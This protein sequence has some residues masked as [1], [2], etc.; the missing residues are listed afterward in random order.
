MSK[1]KTKEMKT[2]ELVDELGKDLDDGRFD[3]LDEELNKR[4]PFSYYEEKIGEFEEKI[5]KLE[6]LF[7]KHH[8]SEGKIVVE[9]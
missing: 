2:S 7:G 9:I 4:S 8:H 5:K 6:E 3:E 1:E